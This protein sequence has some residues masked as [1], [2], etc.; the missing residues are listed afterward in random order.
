MDRYKLTITNLI[1]LAFTLFFNFLSA[2]GILNN[3]STGEVSGLYPTKITPAGFAFSIWGLIYTLLIIALA[4]MFYKREDPKVSQVIDAVGYWFI[5]SSLANIGWIIL[6]SYLQIALSTV[7]IVILLFSLTK[8]VMNLKKLAI[9]LN[10]LYSISFG[11][12]TGW[13]LIA[14]V[15]NIAAALVKAEWSGF[16]IDELVWATIIIVVALGIVFLV[17]YRTTNMIIPLPVAWAYY[18]IFKGED[19]TVAL[20]GMVILVGIAI[21]QF[22]RNDFSIQG[23]ERNQVR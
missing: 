4:W 5:L 8:I 21:Y 1:M 18:A 23:V 13:V 9:K 11:L 16:G 3:I 6:F 7:L 19:L 15:V 14:T 17:S 22:Y 12:Y 2:T 10:P 20:L